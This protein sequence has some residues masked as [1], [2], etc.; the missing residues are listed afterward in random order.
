MKPKK[1]R[2]RRGGFWEKRGR[3]RGVKERLVSLPVFFLKFVVKR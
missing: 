3:E 1:K 2:T